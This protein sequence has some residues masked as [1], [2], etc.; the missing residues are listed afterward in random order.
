MHSYNLC[1]ISKKNY[2]KMHY[3]HYKQLHVITFRIIRSHD[4]AIMLL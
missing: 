4:V 2:F 3:T 1:T